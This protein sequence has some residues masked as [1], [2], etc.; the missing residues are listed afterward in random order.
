MKQ[1]AEFCRRVGLSYN[2]GIGLTAAVKREAPRQRNPKLWLAVASSMEDGNS[3]A[4]A[5]RPFQKQLGGMFVALIEVGEESGHLG[6]MLNE[7]ADYYEQ[8]LQIRRDFIRSITWP[9]VEFAAAVVIIGVL[10][11]AL[12]I[13]EGITGTRMDILGFGLV[14]VS[15]F[16]RYVCFW[17]VLAAAVVFLYKFAQRNI[18]TSRVIH[19][20]L[21]RIPKIGTLFKTLALMKLAWGLH[22]TMKTGMDIRKALTLSFQGTGFTP[23]SGQLPVILEHIEH[24]SSLTEAFAAARNFDYDFISSIDSGEQSGNLPELMQRL[25][26]RYRQESLLSIKVLSVVGGFAVYAGVAACIIFIIFRLFSFYL[27]VLTEAGQ[28]I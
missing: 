8:M 17:A 2:A 3:F 7:L 24:G 10:I 4:E 6:E 20:T 23:V 11:L 15:G 1:L 14:G 5:L 12:G 27:G 19:Y 22:L 28:G 18:S 25:T 21:L 9:V 26:E 13:V 16:I